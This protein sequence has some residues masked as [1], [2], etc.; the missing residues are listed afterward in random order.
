[1]NEIE[2][3]VVPET[4]EEVTPEVTPE[5]SGEEVEVDWKSEAEK[6]KELANNYKIRAEKAEKKAKESP[7]ERTIETKAKEA[8]LSTKDLYALMDAKVP[9]EDISLVE[10]FAK[11]KGISIGEALRSS[12]VKVLLN[13]E[14]EKRHTASSTNVSNARRSSSKLSDEA[15]ISN[16]TSG[17]LPESDDDIARLMAAKRKASN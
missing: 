3:V 5:E 17:R 6:A 4:T 1:M 12:T 16:A 2:E 11:L 13:E 8:G 10:D 14:S 7:A 9:Q 15:L